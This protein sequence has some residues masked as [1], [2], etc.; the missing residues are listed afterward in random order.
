MPS[1]E[2]GAA[3]ECRCR[4]QGEEERV[5]EDPLCRIP[6]AAHDVS[7]KEEVHIPYC[8][9]DARGC[10]ELRLRIGEPSGH[11]CSLVCDKAQHPECY[12][13]HPPPRLA[14]PPKALLHEGEG[15]V[16]KEHLQQH[17]REPVAPLHGTAH[18]LHEAVGETCLADDDIGT[19]EDK[20]GQHL[21]AH[22]L[23][24]EG[25]HVPK[26][27]CEAA[28]I[29]EETTHEEEQG[30]AEEHEQR[31]GRRGL[32][33]LLECE[34]FGMVRYHHEHGEAPHGIQP[35]YSPIVYLSVHIVHRC[36]MNP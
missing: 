30:H 33:R 18:R 4:E 13:R 7:E 16:Y 29:C 26:G 34:Q 6:M 21:Y 12:Y 25:C 20:G 9:D 15:I 2:V 22:L 27:G 24:D 3:Y 28:A 36:A 14:L 23:P 17:P 35:L 19:Q 1:Q 11:V 5:R 10:H 32:L 31:H 8:L